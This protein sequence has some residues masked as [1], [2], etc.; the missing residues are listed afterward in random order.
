MYI[1]LMVH[2][3]ICQVEFMML[4]EEYQIHRKKPG[5]GYRIMDG[6]H[7]NI[8]KVVKWKYT[9]MK[10]KRVILCHFKK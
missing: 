3:L 7:Q 4:T 2:H 9:V 10:M 1:M 5:N 6:Y 8:I